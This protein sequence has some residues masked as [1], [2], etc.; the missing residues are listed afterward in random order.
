MVFI[1]ITVIF[2]IVIIIIIIIISL[3][4]YSDTGFV[5][6]S[7]N[8]ILLVELTLTTVVEQ[9]AKSTLYSV[10]FDLG[11]LPSHLITYAQTFTK[12]AWTPFK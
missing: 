1:I 2:I 4:L 10:M 11:V 5:K 7:F 6:F 3:S 12:K 9:T 8:T